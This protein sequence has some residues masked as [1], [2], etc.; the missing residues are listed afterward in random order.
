MVA[1]ER[2]K[3]KNESSPGLEATETARGYVEQ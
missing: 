2:R 3:L 1:K